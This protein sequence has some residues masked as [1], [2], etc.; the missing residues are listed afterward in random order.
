MK[1][2]GSTRKA[3]QENW[4]RMALMK[5]RTWMTDNCASVYQPMKNRVKTR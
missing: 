5:V 2:S 1:I 4:C 3:S